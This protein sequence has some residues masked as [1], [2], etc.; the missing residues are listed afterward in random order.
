MNEVKNCIDK[1]SYDIKTVDKYVEYIE[2]TIKDN[3]DDI[4]IYIDNIDDLIQELEVSIK[5]WKISKDNFIIKKICIK[6]DEKIK[7]YENILSTLDKTITNY[8]INNNERRDL[9]VSYLA[10]E[11]LVDEEFLESLDELDPNT[12]KK[13]IESRFS[14]KSE[15]INE[16][17]NILKY[18]KSYYKNKYIKQTKE[19]YENI[20]SLRI[21][22]DI[23]NSDSQIN[24]YRQ[25][26]I[27][28]MTIFDANMFDIFNKLFRIDFFKFM[29]A[30]K[31][32]GKIEY[33]VFSSNSDF[34]SV[35]H[36]IVN[37]L[38]NGIYISELLEI[39]RKYD[40]GIFKINGTCKFKD[41]IEIISRR[42]IHIHN[43]GNVDKKYLKKEVEI[44]SHKK[45][46]INIYNFEHNQYAYI[47]REYYMKA[48]GIIKGIIE[49]ISRLNL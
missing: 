41:I 33:K 7:E 34:E 30:N 49:N 6:L 20:K 8:T 1:I 43:N 17:E 36:E 11:Y 24:V 10:P 16:Y 2:Y 4:C 3:Y 28:L 27:N 21:M 12:L 22:Y 31:P 37:N 44:S 38:L 45:E 26:F 29:K 46:N 48:S 25:S 39:V 47:D 35:K 19:H 18:C 23:F 32:S 14:F 5:E 15:N 13:E 42:N 9:V 40:S